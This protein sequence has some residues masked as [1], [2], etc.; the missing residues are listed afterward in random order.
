MTLRIAFYPLLGD[1]VNGA[2]GDV[3]DALS[4]ACTTFGVCTSLGFGVDV[5]LSGIRRLDCGAGATCVSSIPDASGDSQSSKEWKVG[6]IC[7]ITFAA[8]VSVVTGLDKGLKTFSQ[9]TFFMGNLLLLSLLYLDNTWYLLNSYVQSL[10][11]YLQYVVMVGFQTDAF[12][13]LSLEFNPTS[14]IWDQTGWSSKSGEWT[15]VNKVH[16]SVTA[17]TG[18]P[19]ASAAEYYGS[20]P[21][22]WIDWWTIFYWGWWVSW[23]PFVGIF[24]GTISRGRTIKQVV[25]GA[26]IAPIVYSFFFLIVLGCLGIKMQRV[27][28]LGLN[29][30]PNVNNGQ[31]NCTAQG[32]E[33]NVPVSTAAVNLADIGYFSLAC[34]AHPDRLFDVLSP[35]GNEM[36]MY[37]A[38]ISL[39]GV[40]LYFV[41]SSD[42]GS[43]V[44]ELLSSGGLLEGPILQRMY[45]A[46]TEGACACALMYAGGSAALS[47][48]QAISII[49]GFPLTVAICF[50]C[51]SLH[52]AAKW[53]RGEKD[54]CESTRF[55]TGVFDWTE[56][57]RPNMPEIE[58]ITL[59]TVGERVSSLGVS[60]IAPFLTLHD[61]NTRIWSPAR[62][63]AITAVTAALFVSWIGC[64]FGELNSINASYVGWAIYT[65]FVTTI[66]YVRVK[67]RKA[68]NVYGFWLEDFF[69]CLVM[70]PCVCSQLSLQ[71]K[72][73]MP[74]VDVNVDPNEELYSNMVRGGDGIPT[75]EVSPMA[76]S[77]AEPMTMQYYDTRAVP[78]MQA[79][80]M[81]MQQQV[82]MPMM[83]M[84]QQPMGTSPP[85]VYTSQPGF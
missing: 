25:W 69:T 21:S 30:A 73:V 4:M 22:A 53:D 54:I 10:G 84:Q 41:T 60:I 83:Q 36:F 23:A 16:E 24:I 1:V 49:S 75:K 79:V 48:L 62:A 55:I 82:Q 20:H 2:F 65:I 39:I 63:S 31:I 47:A 38:S 50:F 43:Y 85:M 29:V 3:V 33:G 80:P 46:I 70:W 44:D 56:G 7:I 57:F 11:H 27:T 66:L 42:S 28:E 58:G 18:M 12:E 40:T 59:P 13:Q 74:L 81:Q 45:W 26:F 14:N 72:K 6:I 52:R 19:M 77:P 68:Y 8:T 15:W 17:A 51:S 37:L 71:A 78:P 61:M 67:A 35:Y 64:M 76:A 9:I 32:Y 5:I 34:R